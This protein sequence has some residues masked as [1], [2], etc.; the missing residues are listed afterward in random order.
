MLRFDAL[1]PSTFSCLIRSAKPL[2]IRCCPGCRVGLCWRGV[3][4]P[5]NGLGVRVASLVTVRGTQGWRS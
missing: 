3:R 4:D 5:P 2:A 1:R